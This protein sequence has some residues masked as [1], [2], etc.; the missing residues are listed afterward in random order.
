[1]STSFKCPSDDCSQHPYVGA[2]IVVK[3]FLISLYSKVKSKS[4]ETTLSPE[5][6]IQDE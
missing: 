1:M 2:G 3:R 6:N 5:M 4:A